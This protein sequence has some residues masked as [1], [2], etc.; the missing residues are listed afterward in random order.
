M[1]YKNYIKFIKS[2]KN[3]KLYY[4]LLGKYSNNYPVFKILVKSLIW[5]CIN[6]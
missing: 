4:Y 1:K 6:T 2:N 5:I 3:L